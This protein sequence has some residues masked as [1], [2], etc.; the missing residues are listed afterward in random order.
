M[1]PK[2]SK[3]KKLIPHI[4]FAILLALQSMDLLHDHHDHDH[5]ETGHYCVACNLSNLDVHI[6]ETISCLIY[7][8]G[9][10]SRSH[11]VSSLIIKEKLL[12][13]NNPRSPPFS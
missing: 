8:L 5:E 9:I 10:I 2:N 6:D 3:Y 1:F 4:T 11:Y 13:F 12:S 7:N